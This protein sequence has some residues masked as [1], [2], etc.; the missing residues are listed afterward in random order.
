M[1][2]I[3]EIFY[4]DETIIYGHVSYG[5][6]SGLKLS[7]IDVN[8]T[9]TRYINNYKEATKTAQSNDKIIDDAIKAGLTPGKTLE[10]LKH[11]KSV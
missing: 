5:Y 3:R 4:S 8:V 2:R 1:P 6:T 9:C 11:L 7:E 10:S